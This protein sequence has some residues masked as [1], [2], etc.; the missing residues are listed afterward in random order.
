MDA[1][2]IL[3]AIERKVGNPPRTGLMQA[4]R[5]RKL[6]Q[7][8]RAGQRMKLRPDDEISRVYQNEDE[9]I[10]DGVVRWAAVVQANT[11]LYAA[12]PHTSP[13]QLVYCP[14]GVAPLPTVQATAANIFA[15]KDTIPI[16]EDEQRL[17]EMITDEYIRALDWKVPH[18]LS[19]G[20][21]MVTTI[22]PVPRAHVPEGLLAMSILPIL[23]HPQSYLSVVIPQT[24]WEAEFREEWKHRAQEIKQQQLERRQHFEASRRQAAE[25]LKKTKFEVPPVTITQRAAK[26]L[27]SRMAN[28]GT[29][30]AETRIRVLA[31]LL[32]N[33]SASYNL[34]FE[35][36]NASQGDD[37]K[38]RAH[39]LH[40]VVDYEAL[41]QLVGYTIDWMQTDNAEGFEFLSPLG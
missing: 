3:L 5:N 25:E 16:A 4:L 30:S 7:A 35:A 22:V 36:M 19:E 34:Q 14:A 40:F 38:F 33:G 24:F 13:A 27:S 12:D 2:Q 6:V 37:L 31:N 9:I 1:N 18:S 17:A 26:E 28:A 39:G 23:A 10:R 29:S 20:F 41:T 15:L 8:I 11:T 32:D 21:D